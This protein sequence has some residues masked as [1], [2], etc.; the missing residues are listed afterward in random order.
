MLDVNS[1]IQLIQ[2]NTP[3][4]LDTELDLFNAQ[5]KVSQEKMYSDR[6]YPPFDRVMMDGIAV[7]YSAI[8]KKISQFKI[9]GV[10]A[11]GTP[12]KELKEELNCFEVMTGASMPLGADLVIPYEEVLISETIAK[13]SLDLEYTKKANIHFKGSDIK[14]GD[15]ILDKGQ[16]LNGAHIGIGAS[17][18]KDKIL[19]NKNLRINII[20]TGDELVDINQVPKDYQIRRSNSWALR[21]SLKIFGHDNIELSH[22]NDNL[23]EI[24][25]HFESAKNK[26]D[27]LIYSGGVSKGKFDFLPS[28]WEENGVEKIFHCIKQRPGKPL[29]FGVDKISKTTV[30]GLPGNPVSSLVCLHRYFLKQREIYVVLDEDVVFNK[31]LTYFLPVKIYF[32]KEAKILAT[33]VKIKNSGEFSA[34]AYSDGFVELPREKNEFKKGEIYKFFSWR[35]L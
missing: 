1:A 15:I 35:P 4:Y 30:Y 24:K 10:C 31:D 33:P 14:K 16:F 27:V 22:L 29:W 18:G 2:E 21:A 11:A 20:S 23:D 13:I 32:S 3:V 17:I 28:F 8:E 34:L 26:F 25:N 19:T 5:G 6:E 7:K 12:Q 9:I